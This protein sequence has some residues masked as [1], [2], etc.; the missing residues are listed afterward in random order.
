M[1]GINSSYNYFIRYFETRG[2]VRPHYPLKLRS[3]SPLTYAILTVLDSPFYLPAHGLHSAGPLK[4][5]DWLACLSSWLEEKS[6]FF[7]GEKKIMV[8]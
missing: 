3:F 1:C 5:S 8:L 4:F 2:Q 7:P 6:L